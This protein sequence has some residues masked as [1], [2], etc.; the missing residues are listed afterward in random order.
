MVF[1]IGELVCD[2]KGRS[3]VRSPTRIEPRKMEREG[4]TRGG[5][6]CQISGTSRWIADGYR[7]GYLSTPGQ[8]ICK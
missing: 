2:G 7:W 1:V 6:S 3:M 4:E 8:C 5:V